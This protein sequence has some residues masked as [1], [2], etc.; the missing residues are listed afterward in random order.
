[1]QLSQA[2]FN[3]L[4]LWCFFYEIRIYVMCLNIFSQLVSL[5]QLEIL[6]RLLVSGTADV[7]RITELFMAYNSFYFFWHNLQCSQH[8]RVTIRVKK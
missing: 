3:L 7:A 8:Q 2:S 6:M 1:M 4:Y 5:F